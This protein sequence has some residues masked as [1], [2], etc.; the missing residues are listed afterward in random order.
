MAKLTTVVTISANS[1]WQAVSTGVKELTIE[2]QADNPVG[3]QVQ[4]AA[5]AVI[6][7]LVYASDDGHP[8][9]IRKPLIRFIPGAPVFA[10]ITGGTQA[11]KSAKLIVTQAI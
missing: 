3:G 1:T 2:L 11:G 6:G 5:A 4:I 10:K 9:S 7:D 8:L